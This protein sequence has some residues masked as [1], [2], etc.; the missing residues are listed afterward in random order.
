MPWKYILGILIISVV[1]F[2]VLVMS[3]PYL[4]SRVDTFLHP[5][6]NQ[7]GASY[8]LQQSLIAIGSGGVFGRGLG[9]G[10]QKFSYLPEPQGDSIFAVIGEETGFIGGVGVNCF[11]HNLCF[12]WIQDWILCT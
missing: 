4:K 5:S 8:Q 3:T 12:S 2:G 6:R 7:S 1:G 9:Q 11:I 10:I